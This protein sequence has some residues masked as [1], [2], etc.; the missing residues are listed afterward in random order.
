MVASRPL[1]VGGKII[2]GFEIEFKD[3]KAV[4]C[5][6]EV[7][8]EL[9]RKTIET[10]E[11]SCYLGE[12]AFVPYHSPISESG[13][14]YYNTLIDENASCHIALG[15]GFAGSVGLSSADPSTWASKNLN[16]SKI[17]I[18]FMIGCKDTQIIGYT[19]DGKEV[20]IFKDGDFAL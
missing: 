1:L 2:D 20:V 15:K 19:R 6:A 18:D 12:V 9:L 5:K 14:I 16:Y 8:E 4:S 11:G 10:D 7:G 3:G 13:Y 17:H